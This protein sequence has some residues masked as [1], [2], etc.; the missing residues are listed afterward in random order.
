MTKTYHFGPMRFV[1]MLLNAYCVEVFVIFYTY[2]LGQRLHVMISVRQVIEIPL[3]VVE[4]VTLSLISSEAKP[5]KL[6][7]NIM[8]G[9]DKN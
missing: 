5:Q 6:F 7:C 9:R 1:K 2:R 4:K 8:V 3:E